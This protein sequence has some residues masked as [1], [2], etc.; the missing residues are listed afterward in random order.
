[1]KC[2]Y[3]G[4]RTI[5]T[6][7]I[8]VLVQLSILQPVALA[9]D[10]PTEF[11]PALHLGIL[12][13]FG[14][15][16]GTNSVFKPFR[17]ERLWGSASDGA[18]LSE[19]PLSWLWDDLVRETESSGLLVPIVKDTLNV[20]WW[21][22]AT[23]QRPVG[24]GEPFSGLSTAT[25]T[26]FNIW[27]RQKLNVQFYL[28]A[29]NEPGS[30]PHFTGR[31][32]DISRLGFNSAEIDLASI[33][34]ANHWMTVQFGRGR[35]IWGALEGDNLALGSGSASYEQLMFEGRYKRFR[36]R[37]FYAFLESTLLNTDNINRY[38]V[39]HGLEYSNQKNL[40][41]GLT[42]I[43][44]FSGVNRPLDPA[45]LNPLLPQVVTEQ[46]ER[47]NQQR[48]SNSAN[49][50]WTLSV[51]WMPLP[52]FRFSGNFTVDEFQL[53]SGD[54]DQ[55]R[56]DATAVQIRTAYSRSVG[57]V[58]ATASFDYTRIGTFT[59]S[60]GTGQ[61]NFVSRDR[62]LGAE[63]GSD[64]DQWRFGLRV[65][66][67]QRVIASVGF[68]GLRAGERSLLLSP[69]RG[70]IAEEFRSAPFPSDAVQN[71][72]FFD[73][74][75]R[76]S[77]IRNVDLAASGRFS[78]SEGRFEAEQSYVIFSINAYLPWWFGL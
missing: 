66:L 22:G 31:P 40:V 39:G 16:W 9:Q 37:F 6:A 55:G 26:N 50:V 65:V 10:I 77:P 52:G 27:F 3:T 36:G 54:R 14:H 24:T 70:F 25:Y 32:R 62:P 71:T 46:N 17:W 44:T 56:P 78:S 29:T 73:W 19:R 64:A 12:H 43:I 18:R 49:A 58:G 45:F 33:S 57:L 21:N 8:V 72:D 51:D 15:E 59:F 69:Y 20:R 75:V 30:L 68:G 5:I 7:A 2:Q 76:Y 34:Y 1:M 4:K 42:E 48:L 67:P 60:H 38:L 28:R 23:L 11:W 74:M 47:T 61:N 35:Q 13:D 41:V 53:D 63:I